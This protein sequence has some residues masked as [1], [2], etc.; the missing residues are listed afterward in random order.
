MSPCVLQ[1]E[2]INIAYTSRIIPCEV[3]RDNRAA[4]AF[5]LAYLSCLMCINCSCHT[6]SS[7]LGTFNK[8]I[9][10]I[11]CSFTNLH[12]IIPAYITEYFLSINNLDKKINGKWIRY[13]ICF[14]SMWA[15]LQAP[16]HK[17]VFRVQ[18]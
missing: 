1:K 17:T 4:H 15:V 6:C 18:L 13:S 7:V 3:G 16:Y 8:L 14:V 5:I 12:S 9:P 11:R 10:T 2:Q